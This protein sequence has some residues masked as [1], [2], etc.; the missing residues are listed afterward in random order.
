MA[1]TVNEQILDDLILHD[2]RLDKVSEKF[3]RDLLVP[4]NATLIPE[5]HAVAAG[6]ISAGV[7][8]AG[9]SNS[10]VREMLKRLQ[11]ITSPAYKAIYDQM[12]AELVPLA[13]FEVK[14]GR[15][16]LLAKNL[17]AAEL[18]WA[19]NTPS[20]HTVAAIVTGDP[21][22][23][24]LLR[25]WTRSLEASLLSGVRDELVQ[26]ILR[27]EPTEVVARRLEG[28]ARQ[29]GRGGVYG[30][31]RQEM[32]ALARTA[33]AH[34]SNQARE[35]LWEENSE[36]IERIQWTATLDSRTCPICGELDGQT[37]PPGDG[38]R[39]PEH[40]QCRCTA[41]PVL[42]SWKSLGFKVKDLPPSTRSSMNGQVPESLKFPQWL[43][44]QPNAVHD[45]VLGAARA[46]LWRSG[47]VQF[48][49]FTGSAGR[50]L[51]LAELSELG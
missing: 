39:P 24:R 16:T 12:K 25:T 2:T 47:R 23:G 32:R 42:K 34:V 49:E 43:K 31:Q 4:M 30:K 1:K 14:W 35:L 44:G 51:T 17:A 33:F 7:A 19:L 38:V 29:R 27:G 8:R 18:Q 21:L 10:E 28:L 15:E 9:I 11:A 40:H 5:V 22:Q 26:G 37:F 3:V 20:P 41:V 50:F 13:R 36:L 48:R 45:E 6:F 46:K